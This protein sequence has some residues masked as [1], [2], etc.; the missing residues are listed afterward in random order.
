MLNGYWLFGG[1]PYCGNPDFLDLYIALFKHACL[2]QQRVVLTEPMIVNSRNFRIAYSSDAEFRILARSDIV[3]IAHMDRV[4]NRHGPPMNL[5]QAKEF[6]GL[7]NAF[8]NLPAEY[9]T[10]ERDWEL[11]E[12]QSK[13]TASMLFPNS[14]IRDPLFTLNILQ[15]LDTPFIKHALGPFHTRY[16][17][18]VREY[19]TRYQASDEPL[20]IIH[21]STGEN[22]MRRGNIASEFLSAVSDKVSQAELSLLRGA[23]EEFGSAHYLRTEAQVMGKDPILTPSHGYYSRVMLNRT[24][25]DLFDREPLEH[26]STFTLRSSLDYP[27]LYRNLDFA[28]LEKLRSQTDEGIAFFRSIDGHDP[29]AF[30]TAAENYCRRVERELSK[31]FAPL[32]KPSLEHDYIYRFATL[33]RDTALDPRGES[34]GLTRAMAMAAFALLFPK[35]AA[36]ALLAPA[37]LSKPLEQGDQKIGQ[38]A[39]NAIISRISSLLSAGASPIEAKLLHAPTPGD[40]MVQYR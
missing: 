21:F 36:L 33:A 14:G 16:C 11:E 25:E 24:I 22:W 31:S 29:T 23:I 10:A 19:V 7:I 34:R 8:A 15:N 13:P 1:Q 18:L 20:G 39:E 32:L 26:V 6:C 37:F 40:S 28:L 3:A 12:L 35:Q 17:D 30:R 9:R 4:G 5:I 2:F 27:Q 38:I